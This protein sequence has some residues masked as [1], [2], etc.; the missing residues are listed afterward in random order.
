M[1]ALARLH[2]RVALG[3][4]VR[5]PL[6]ADVEKRLS[7]IVADWSDELGAA[8]V[9]ELGE[10]AGLDALARYGNAF[11]A[12]YRDAYPPSIAAADVAH[13]LEIDQGADLITAL[14]RPLGAAPE[15]VRFTLM[16]PG[17]PLVLSEVL[18]LLED[19]GV[20]VVDERTHEIRVE[21]RSVWRYDIGLR[22]SDPGRI[23]DRATREEFC[24][25]FAALFRGELESDGL[26]Q[27]VVAGGLSARQVDVLRAYAKYLRQIGLS[28]SQRYVETTMARHAPIV[29]ALVRLF[30]TRF[31]PSIDP[32]VAH[33]DSPV[34]A[35]DARA[36]TDSI[37]AQLDAVPSLDEDRIL[38]SFLTLI[39]AT[40]RTN[41]Y[42]PRV[43]G[44]PRSGTRPVLSF[45]L[46][47]EGIP[48][49]PLPRPMFEIWVYSPRVEGVHLRGGPV[50]RGGLRWSDRREDFRTEVLGLMK[51]QMVKNAVIIPVGAKGGFVVKR[52]E[53]ITDAETLRTE[54]AACYREFV[55]GLLDVT[56][57]VV[58]GEVVPPP[59]VVRHDQDD[60]YLVVAADKGTATFSDLANSVAESYG[61]WLGDAFASGGS[62]GYDHKAMGI[63][64]RGAWESARRHARSL[65]RD[66]DTDPLTVVGIGDMSGDV[67][68]NGMLRSPQPAAG[69]RLRPPP[70]LPRPRPRPGPLVRRATAPLRLPPLQLGR[71]R[72]DG[73]LDRRRRLA[74]VGQG[75]RPL[76][77]GASGPRRHRGDHDAER[78]AVGHPQ[79]ARGP[80]LERRHRHLRQGVDG[81]QCGGR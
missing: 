32:D 78:A 41:A 37:A 79:G 4:E 44:E 5:H 15:E 53:R 18:P 50:A 8:L 39:L 64:A 56:D 10:D 14:H 17:A 77:R 58:D 66:A 6:I 28:F 16:R 55:A 27:L 46:D 52:R 40:Q 19:L 3:G 72:P 34:R 43:D 30:E 62:A 48:D 73:H 59:D 7:T 81:E 9:G 24:D 22:V 31:D 76:G 35:A 49:L 36:L 45:K 33:G 42:R 75:H 23:D 67:F 11:P 47:P 12:D 2:V 60:P 54:V 61:F 51:A 80:A 63:T 70:H 65:G 25:T 71:L 1:G 38:R 20:T 69:G 29:G 74:A 26:N 13:L 68:G 21:G 57:N